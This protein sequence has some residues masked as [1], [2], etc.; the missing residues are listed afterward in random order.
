MT[1]GALQ[2][3]NLALALMTTS[4][5]AAKNMGVLGSPQWLKYADAGLYVANR[6]ATILPDVLSNPGKYDVMTPA[7]IHALLAPLSW[8]EL[9]VRAAAELAAEQPPT[10]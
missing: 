3:A 10:P 8:E 7:Q 1:L 9:E 4:F 6:L 5:T 2:I